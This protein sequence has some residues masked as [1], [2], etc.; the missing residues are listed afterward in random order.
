MLTSLECIY[1]HLQ[2][3]QPPKHQKE[4]KDIVSLTLTLGW[5][6]KKWPSGPTELD[7]EA[8]NLVSTIFQQ[9]FIAKNC[10]LMEIEAYITFI[11]TMVRAI[12]TMIIVATN[13]P[14]LSSIACLFLAFL[15]SSSSCIWPLLRLPTNSESSWNFV[16]FHRVDSTLS[17]WMPI[18]DKR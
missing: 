1:W 13:T 15:S 12:I 6:N 4:I 16:D 11:D 18:L 3:N 10:W 5:K 7:L 8:G 9:C 14:T 2:T 17:I